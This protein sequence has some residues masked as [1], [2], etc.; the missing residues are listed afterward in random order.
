M[1]KYTIQNGDTMT[2]L[3]KKFG[4]SVSELAKANDIEDPDKIYIGDALSV[5]DPRQ[6]Q[7][8]GPRNQE[9]LQAL[10]KQ[11]SSETGTP[12]DE[13]MKGVQAGMQGAPRPGVQ[14][15]QGAPQGGLGAMQQR[16]QM[17]Q[18]GM[19]R[20][21]MPP[22]GAPQGMPPQA[23]GGQAPSAPPG[24]GQ[25]PPQGMMRGQPMP[26]GQMP[27]QGQMRG[28][29]QGMQQGPLGMMFGRRGQ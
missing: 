2:G 28:Q 7:Q 24:A 11:L 13:L 9:E 3:A 25:M 19:Q 26:Q 6:H 23:M 8:S 29:G 17:P 22:Q 14:Q 1:P 10:L 21:Q 4:V 18:Q 27:P 16:P 12:V 5:P 20:P 15:P